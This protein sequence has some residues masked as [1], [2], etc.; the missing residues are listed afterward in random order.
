MYEQIKSIKSEGDIPVYIL[1]SAIYALKSSAVQDVDA[2]MVTTGAREDAGPSSL[3][4]IYLLLSTSIRKS[5]EY[6]K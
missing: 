3:F 6:Q 1:I 2:A 4:D 5:T